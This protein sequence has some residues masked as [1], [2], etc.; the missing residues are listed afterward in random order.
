M[1]RSEPVSAWVRKLSTV[2]PSRVRE[3]AG[4][5]QAVRRLVEQRAALGGVVAGEVGTDVLDAPLDRVERL[6][7]QGLLRGHGHPRGAAGQDQRRRGD[8][9]APLAT[10]GGAGRQGQA[11]C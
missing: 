5:G 4:L 1:S 11:G 6:T 2:A 9:Q 10:A 7:G 3:G 8:G